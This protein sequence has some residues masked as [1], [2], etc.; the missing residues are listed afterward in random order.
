MNEKMRESCRE[1]S[2]EHDFERMLELVKQINDLNEEQR[3]EKQADGS[4]HQP[5]LARS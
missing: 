5:F 3:N 4:R 1:A 2:F